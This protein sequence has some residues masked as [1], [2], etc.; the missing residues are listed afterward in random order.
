MEGIKIEVTGNIAR[1]TEKPQRITAGTVGLPIEFTFDGQWDGLSKTAVFRM[2]HTKKIVENLDTE[3]TVPWELLEK[4]GAWLSVGVYGI[5]EDGSVAIPT[6]WVNVGVIKE[7]ADPDGDPGIDPELPVWQKLLNDVGDLQDLDTEDKGDVV[8]A[9]NEVNRIAKAGGVDTDTTLS[10]SGRAADAK[11]TG[12]ALKDVQQSADEAKWSAEKAQQSATEAQQSADAAQQAADEMLPLAGGKMVGSI[13][14]GGNTITGLPTPASNM[15]A[16][17]KGY[18]DSKCKAIPGLIY[19]FAGGEIPDGFLLCDGSIYD[20]KDY[21]ELHGVIGDTFNLEETPEGMFNVPDLCARVPIG[22]GW[23]ETGEV[24]DLGERVFADLAIGE[25]GGEASHELGAK[26]MATHRHYGIWDNAGGSEWG[27]NWGVEKDVTTGGAGAM[28]S[29]IGTSE[30]QGLMTSDTGN[31]YPHTNMQPYLVVNY[32]ISTG[33]GAMVGTTASSSGGSD[34]DDTVIASDKTWSSKN[35]VDKLCPTFTESGSV[36]ACE[37]VEGYPL[38]VASKIIPKQSGSGDPSPENVRPIESW[39]GAKLWQGGKNLLKRPMEYNPSYVPF[40]E[41]FFLKA[42]TYY[43]SVKPRVAGVWRFYISLYYPDGTV[44]GTNCPV[45]NRA[46]DP[47][48]FG[49]YFTKIGDSGRWGGY[50]NGSATYGIVELVHD[51]YIAINYGNNETENLFYDVQLE[52]G[53]V[54]TEYEPY[55]EAEEITIDFGQ[56]V[57]G[58]S[59]N[60][61]TGELT[62]DKQYITVDGNCVFNGNSV[63]DRTNSTNRFV[64]V[65]NTGFQSHKLAKLEAW[66][67]M[68]LV[69]EGIDVWVTDNAKTI[70]RFMVDVGTNLHINISNESLGISTEDDYD[71]RTNKF[72]SFCEAHPLHFVLPLAEHIT[73]QLTPQEILALHGVNTMY[74]DTGDTTVSG[75]ADTSAV[76]EKLTNAIIALGGNV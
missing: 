47:N 57:Y 16:A 39:T 29:K 76:I 7:G 26:E 73:I 48:S 13:A 36:V 6:I 58:G 20:V 9:I 70:N 38:E 65:P 72:K 35:T 25:T 54:G 69:A 37:P 45:P 2:R 5:N 43:F 11:A 60:W 18:V 4:P 24:T 63:Y 27:I 10:Q 51:S 50:A 53:S 55:T 14:M 1:V 41:C 8:E 59:Y 49:L 62:V 56:A 12:D 34:I 22:T 32:I 44:D 33:K 23:G 67:D 21:T 40:E 19:P 3:T 31:S 75:R 30:T 66:S 61:K 15:D 46:D 74:T 68:L 71:T 17:T 28:M 42:G 52:V 64:V